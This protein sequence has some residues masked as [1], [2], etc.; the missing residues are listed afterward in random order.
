MSSGTSNADQTDKFIAW[1][2]RLHQERDEQG[3]ARWIEPGEELSED[4]P[5]IQTIIGFLAGSNPTSLLQQLVFLLKREISK[6]MA[7]IVEAYTESP[8]LQQGLEEATKL[9]EYKLSF[10]YSHV[11]SR[12]LS[13]D[14]SKW[15]NKKDFIKRCIYDHLTHIQVLFD[16]CCPHDKKNEGNMLVY[17]Q[18]KKYLGQCVLWLWNDL[19]EKATETDPVFLVPI[20]RRLAMRDIL[21]PEWNMHGGWKETFDNLNRTTFKSKATG[22]WGKNDD[23]LDKITTMYMHARNSVQCQQHKAAG[24]G[25]GGP[26]SAPQRFTYF[27]KCSAKLCSDVETKEKPHT[28]RCKRCYYYHYC[29]ET[30]A[31]YCNKYTNQHKNFCALVPEYGDNI[32][33]TKLEMENFLG[34]N[35]KEEPT[36][37]DN[38]CCYA[39]SIP[40]YQCKTKLSNCGRCKAVAYCSVFCQKWSWKEG[41]HNNECCASSSF[42]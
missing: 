21:D 29:S 6:I 20:L 11:L 31:T 27:P 13:S 39:C 22:M 33:R 36:S 23:V 16:E 26:L 2:N 35:Q 34:K 1:L 4:D 19:D 9:S 24:Y 28:L 40:A 17:F 42:K 30:C 18:G 25:T 7:R 8:H 3:G 15:T 32:L 41:G 12:I 14:D 10:I 37:S 5:P 38:E